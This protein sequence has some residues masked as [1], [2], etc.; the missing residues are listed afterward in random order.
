MLSGLLGQ[1]ETCQAVIETE[2]KKA[3]QNKQK[4]QK[5]IITKQTQPEYRK[6]HKV[7]IA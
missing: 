1:Q 5:Q 3:M 7:K 2:L 4:R 6:I